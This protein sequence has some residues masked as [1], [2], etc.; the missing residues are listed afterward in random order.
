MKV[1][2][3][4]HHPDGRH[5]RRKPHVQQ[6]HPLPQRPHYMWHIIHQNDPHDKPDLLV[7]VP[8]L[9]HHPDGRHWGR[10]ALTLQTVL[11]SYVIKTRTNTKAPI[12]NVW[13]VG[14]SFTNLADR[15]NRELGG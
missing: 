15:I 5:W 14:E 3:L 11:T 9:Y 7:K 8:D 10:T 1:P 13:T 6:G 12:L 2:D 4:Y